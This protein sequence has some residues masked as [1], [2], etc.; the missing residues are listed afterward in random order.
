MNLLDIRKQVI[1]LSGRL[2]LVVDTTAYLD[3]G[4]NIYIQAGTKMLD[5]L[6]D[7]GGEEGTAFYSVKSGKYYLF[8]PNVRVIQEVWAYDTS[9]MSQ[10][11]EVTRAELR[12]FFPS[13][14]LSG[15][16]GIPD[17]YYPGA[18]KPGDSDSN[19]TV[20]GFLIQ[21]SSDTDIP[22][23]ILFPPTDRD[24]T[25]EIT[26]KFFSFPLDGDTAENYWSVNYP[27]LLVWAAL[28]QLEVTYRNT[29]G[30]KDWLASINQKLY[31]LGLDLADQESAN[32]NQIRG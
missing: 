1:E 32:I 29:T 9:T 23:G 24:L 20:N 10:L 4:A 21:L 31:D 5:Q 14:V 28:Y 22:N 18:L 3:N 12:E 11:E 15:E 25:F 26:G 13:K 2:D 27:L 16:A 19:L 6:A 17:K 8:I 30:A 7:T